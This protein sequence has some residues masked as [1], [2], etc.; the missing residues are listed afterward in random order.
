MFLSG[1]QDWGHKKSRK[2]VGVLLW[3]FPC[4][5]LGGIVVPNFREHLNHHVK[6]RFP[7]FHPQDSY[8]V[9]LGARPE[10][11]PWEATQVCHFWN[12]FLICGLFHLPQPVRW[13]LE[14][15]T[16]SR[17]FTTVFLWPAFQE[18][19][20]MQ[21]SISQTSIGTQITCQLM[22]RQ[23]LIGSVWSRVQ[24]HAFQLSL[25]MMQGCH[26]E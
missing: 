4:T 13:L 23:I 15:R 19:S 16:L 7:R 24:I 5:L 26:F 12:P 18:K 21:P 20:E 10:T 25:A 8:S 11:A 1:P 22:K 14:G 2:D 17:L 9:S 3:F 6:C